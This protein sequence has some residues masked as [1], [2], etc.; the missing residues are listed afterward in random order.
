MAKAAEACRGRD[1]TNE[2]GCDRNF[3]VQVAPIAATGVSAV[4]HSGMHQQASSVA[5]MQSMH[6]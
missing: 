5:G 1:H 4:T 6:M 2:W 3:W